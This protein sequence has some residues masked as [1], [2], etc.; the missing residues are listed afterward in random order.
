MIP[1]DAHFHVAAYH[2]E[3]GYQSATPGV[4]AL[5]PLQLRDSRLAVGT[6]RNSVDRQSY[7]AAVVWQP[8]RLGPVRTGLFGGMVTGYRDNPMPFGAVVASY[9]VSRTAELHLTVIPKVNNLS[10]FTAALSVSFK[11]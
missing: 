4:G 7:Y 10:P 5:C 1:C 9:Q 11:L 3:P 8:V 2:A 6:F